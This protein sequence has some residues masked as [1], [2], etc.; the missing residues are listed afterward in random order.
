MDDDDWEGSET[1][2]LAIEPGDYALA[3]PSKVSGVFCD[4]Q[5]SL[6]WIEATDSVAVENEPSNTASF[7]IFRRVATEEALTVHYWPQGQASNGNDYERLVNYT[8]EIPAGQTSAT[9]LIKPRPDDREEGQESVQLTLQPLTH[10]PENAQDGLRYRRAVHGNRPYLG[11]CT[12]AG[13]CSTEARTV[14]KRNRLAVHCLCS[15]R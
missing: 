5:S 12:N 11:R 9:V 7:T 14:V 15:A 8:V 10:V 1:V 2:I 3:S 6:V 4:G 13:S